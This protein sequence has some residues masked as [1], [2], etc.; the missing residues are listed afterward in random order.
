MEQIKIN[1]PLNSNYA[2]L[3]QKALMDNDNLSELVSE[4]IIKYKGWF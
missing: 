2:H 3:K 1:Q 4:V